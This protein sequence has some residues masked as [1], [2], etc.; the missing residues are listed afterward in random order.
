MKQ[1]EEPEVS[2]ALNYKIKT[3]LIIEIDLI[4]EIK[5]IQYED[6]RSNGRSWL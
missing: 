5:K 6:N 2:E 1:K 4:N 3:I